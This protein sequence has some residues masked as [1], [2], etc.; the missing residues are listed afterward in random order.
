MDEIHKRHSSEGEQAQ[1]TERLLTPEDQVQAISVVEA[2]LYTLSHDPQFLSD[3]FLERLKPWL[4]PLDHPGPVDREFIADQIYLG[5]KEVNKRKH[6]LQDELRS[7]SP[8]DSE[9]DQP[10]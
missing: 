6:Q 3:E 2:V 10:A 1:P 4:P 7:K 5:N 8:S 9:Q